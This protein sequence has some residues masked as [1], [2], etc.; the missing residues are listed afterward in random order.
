VTADHTPER[1]DID[2]LAVEICEHSG[3]HTAGY[4]D[5]DARRWGPCSQCIH[6]ARVVDPILAALRAECDVLG[7]R[8]AQVEAL[9]P[10]IL[11][12][13]LRRRLR[14]ALH[15]DPSEAT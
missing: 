9:L 11:N 14:A 12:V 10:Y 6:Y 5:H 7:E 15:P 2:D 4:G 8:T 1:L 3:R 13:T